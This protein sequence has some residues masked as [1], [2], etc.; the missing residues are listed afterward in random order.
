LTL[1]ITEIF[2]SFDLIQTFVPFAA[3]VI[4][5]EVV[6]PFDLGTLVTSNLTLLAGLMGS[7]TFIS[8]T[9]IGAVRWLLK[10]MT[11]STDALRI[12]TKK[13]LDDVKKDTLD[14]VEDNKRQIDDVKTSLCNQVVSEGSKLQIKIDNQQSTIGEVKNILEKVDDKL[15]KN[16]DSITRNSARIESHDMRL[17][18]IENY[19]YGRYSTLNS[20]TSNINSGNNI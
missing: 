4:T 10:Q 16:Q 14:R 8:A 2:T 6:S 13:D 18:N 17:T 12:E 5:K 20:K 9:V 3:Q 11:K 15:D 1:F 7:V 19:V